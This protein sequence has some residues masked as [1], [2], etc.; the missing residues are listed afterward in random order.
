KFGPANLL[1][2]DRYSYWSTDDAVHTPTLTITLPEERRFNVVRL[3]ENI[4]L[5]Q[6][7]ESV[8]I[9]VLRNGQ[10]QKLAGATSIGANRLIRLAEPVTA[11]QLRLTI[12]KSPVSIALSDF[13]LY[14]EPK[15]Q[16]AAPVAAK[17][18]A[19]LSKGGW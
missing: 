10:W 11:K 3:R 8:E 9:E 18:D 12:S 14:L 1:D 2:A 19:S 15:R 13:G 4:K 7:I 17:A 5:G 6:R 16:Q